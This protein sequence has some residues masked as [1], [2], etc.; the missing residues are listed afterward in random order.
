MVLAGAFVGLV[1]AFGFDLGAKPCQD[2]FISVMSACA[3]PQPS[4]G[5]MVVGAALGA[6][7]PLLAFL[8]DKRRG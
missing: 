3:M 6:A 7:L 1:A 8:Y 4:T 2:L 5:G